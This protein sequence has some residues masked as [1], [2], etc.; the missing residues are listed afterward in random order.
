MQPNVTDEALAGP[1][2]LYSLVD[3]SLVTRTH[4]T[5]C[6]LTTTGPQANNSSHYHLNRSRQHAGKE[7][8]EL[9]IGATEEE[10]SSKQSASRG[11]QS[12]RQKQK[13]SQVVTGKTSW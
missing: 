7:V 3:D 9:V 6:G 8:A 5:Q 11:Q 10:T 4:C 12:W 1:R 13:Y 2:A